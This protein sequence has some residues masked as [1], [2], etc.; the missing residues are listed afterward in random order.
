MF[1]I[2]RKVV[3]WILGGIVA[4]LIVAGIWRYGV[5]T[6]AFVVHHY[7]FFISLGALATALGAGIAA[8]QLR[9]KNRLT[10]VNFAAQALKEFAADKDMQDVFY[11]I[12][13]ERFEY[14]KEG[15][16]DGSPEERRID[17]LLRHFAAVALAWKEGLV[18]SGDLVLI[19]YYVVRTMRDRKVMRYV[20][21]VCERWAKKAQKV[22]HPY[23]VLKRFHEYLEK[24]SDFSD[25]AG[26]AR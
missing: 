18:K 15:F 8:Y 13:Y 14:P 2:S 9:R 19:R 3:A 11:D 21:F 23:A 10:S 25:S 26:T 7:Q 1:C 24:S 17:R 4:A 6:F 16:H 5:T 20:D 12:E 22:E